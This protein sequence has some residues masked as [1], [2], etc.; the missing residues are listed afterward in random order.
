MPTDLLQHIR[1]LQYTNRGQAEALLLGF[2]REVYR[3]DVTSVEIR[4]LAISLNSF[5]GF[6]TL[7]N[8]E[9]FFFKSHTETDTVIGEYYQAEL[10]DRVGYPIIKPIFR[11]SDPGKQILIYER[12]QQ[13]SV[14]D[15]A[16]AIET[17]D[18]GIN[19]YDALQNAQ[20]KSD[21]TL[22][23]IYCQ[24]L[25]PLTA[26]SNSNQ[27]IHQLFHHRITQG[28]FDRFY[29]EN[30]VALLPHEELPTKAIMSKHWTI[31]GQIYS[32]TLGGLI[33][34]A[35]DL[36]HPNQATIGVVGHG[37]AHN[38]NVFFDGA[39]EHLTFFDP[40]FAGYHSPLLDLVKPLFHNVFAMWMYYPLEKGNR[41]RFE[42]HEDQD[43]WIYNHD[44]DLHPVRAMFLQS[45]KDYLLKPIIKHLNTLDALPPNYRSYLK[46]ALMCCPLLTMNLTDT[47]RFPPSIAL[48]GFAMAIEMGAESHAQRSLID[49]VLDEIDV[50]P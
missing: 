21:Q 38:G 30:R 25:K 43:R 27:P 45:K 13:P 29:G 47:T 11:S 44:Y 35:K 5:N 20:I 41:L 48:L 4:T 36:L 32:E 31:N 22:F 37:D 24:T 50:I 39:Q 2:L 8:G 42:L 17:A 14:F 1:D 40:A 9:S 34:Q 7:A 26:E 12:I 16:W 15:V 19:S 6:L 33:Q 28:R 3:P 46:L 23:N 18:H 10:L 49:Q